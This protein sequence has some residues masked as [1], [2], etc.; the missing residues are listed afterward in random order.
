MIDFVDMPE[1]SEELA[2][3]NGHIERLCR[4]NNA[5]MQK[6][7]DWILEARGKQIRPILTLLCSKL[8]G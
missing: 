2:K 8:K 4:S 7:V 6:V 3:V 1:M 5:S